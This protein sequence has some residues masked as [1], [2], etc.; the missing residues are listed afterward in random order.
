M[1]MAQRGEEYRET[2]IGVTVEAR[3]TA[4]RDE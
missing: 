2:S 3:I 1:K 4:E